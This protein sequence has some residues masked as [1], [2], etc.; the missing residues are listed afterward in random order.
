MYMLK[1]DIPVIKTSE[2]FKRITTRNDFKYHSALKNVR[3]TT[4]QVKSLNKESSLLG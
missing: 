4:K 3:Q 1:K 2:Y